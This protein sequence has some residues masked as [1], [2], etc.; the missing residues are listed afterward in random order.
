M[1]PVTFLH[2]RGV[3]NQEVVNSQTTRRRNVAN[4]HPSYPGNNNTRGAPPVGGQ[5]LNVPGNSTYTKEKN[6]VVFPLTLRLIRDD[7]E[8]SNSSTLTATAI[9][10]S[11][12]LNEFLKDLSPNGALFFHMANNP[13]LLSVR[14]QLA[15]VIMHVMY[16]S[17]LQ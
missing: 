12:L 4:P 9:K 15:E 3:A 17:R 5:I 14:D 8:K 6:I 7:H 11:D 10:F 1:P 2:G 16:L 13:G